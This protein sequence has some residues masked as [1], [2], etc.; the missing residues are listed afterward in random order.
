MLPTDASEILTIISSLK[1][2]GNGLYDLSVACVK[3]NKV[4]FSDHFA[5]LYNYSLEKE[6]FPDLLKIAQVA[7]GHKSGPVDN[8]DN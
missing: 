3:N 1:N 2:K 4:Q 7:A 8:I 6:S 5:F